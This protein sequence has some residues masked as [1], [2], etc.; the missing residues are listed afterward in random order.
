MSLCGFRRLGFY[1]KMTQKSHGTNPLIRV[2]RMDW[3]GFELVLLTCP[4][5]FIWH[6]SPSWK[7]NDHVSSKSIIATGPGPLQAGGAVHA[8]GHVHQQLYPTNIVNRLITN[9][10]RHLFLLL[11]TF[12]APTFNLNPLSSWLLDHW[13]G[14]RTPVYISGTV[15]GE[16]PDY[17]L[18]SGTVVGENPD[19][20]S[21][22]VLH[23]SRGLKYY[24]STEAVY[25]VFLLVRSHVM[26]EL[27]FDERD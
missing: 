24:C 9:L 23:R 25:Q 16:S 18:L 12:R 22:D 21:W 13:S 7:I 5:T 2:G 15:M 20:V 14:L 6:S 3:I 1:I 17:L 8:E 4:G 26:S 19:H 11:W 27:N 10:L